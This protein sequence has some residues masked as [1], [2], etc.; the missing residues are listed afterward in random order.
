LVRIDKEGGVET[1]LTVKNGVFQ[2]AGTE[3][4]AW[5]AVA[6]LAG[7]I[8]LYSRAQKRVDVL[9]A[10][11]VCSV[12]FAGRRLLVL[13]E[14]SLVTVELD[15]RKGAPERAPGAGGRLLQFDSEHCL[16]LGRNG[17]SWLIDDSGTMM[18][19][20]SVPAG[21]TVLSSSW[22]SKRFVL[23]MPEGGCVYWRDGSRK[24]AWSEAIAG[25]LSPD[26]RYL[27]VTLPGRVQLYEDPA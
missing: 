23:A 20:C 18:P 5:F 10:E 9:P 27:A 12:A 16:L 21:H 11:A 2:I 19:Y 22:C 1:L 25:T 7:A 26:G 13:S 6:D 4:G 8:A 14:Q 3:G 24:E 15:G 17:D